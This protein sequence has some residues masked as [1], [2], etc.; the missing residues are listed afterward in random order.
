[1]PVADA[2]HLRPVGVVAPGFLP[3]IG[4]L[5]RGHQDF[6]T[7]HPVLLLAHDLL[8]L[9]QHLV[10]QRQPGIDA[11][12]RL[13]DHAGAQHQPVR[14][15]LRLGGRLLQGREEIAGKAHGATARVVAVSLR[16]EVARD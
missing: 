11:G 13:A 1:M 10:A 12:A 2:Q 6:L 14:D 8:D 9:L 5:D 3:E 16:F 7:A 4:R 15:D